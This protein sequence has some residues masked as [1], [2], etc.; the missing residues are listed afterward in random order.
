[1]RK[2]WKIPYISNEFITKKN[3]FSDKSLIKT[4]CRNSYFP[5]FLINKHFSI[6]NGTKYISKLI[7]PD[8][9]G[10]K[11]GVFSITKVLGNSKK[12]KKKK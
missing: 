4:N 12:K 5:F 3:F 7:K 9:I 6:Y 11:S 8:M 1:M 2:S 10:L